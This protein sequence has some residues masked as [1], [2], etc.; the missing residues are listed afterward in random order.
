LPIGAQMSI[1]GGVDKALERGAS[2]GC[3]T[4]QLFTRNRNRWEAKPL[5]R[6][7][8]RRFR[9]QQA[10]TEIQPLLA[11]ASYLIN[12]ASPQQEIFDES[13]AAFHL[14]DSRKPLGIGQQGGLA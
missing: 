9:T 10:R 7:E 6:P 11:H 4:I 13:V 12:L 1:A 3:E 5:A 2:L 14:N 8:I